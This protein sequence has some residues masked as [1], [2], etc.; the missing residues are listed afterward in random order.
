MPEARGLRQ[1]RNSPAVLA[2]W[3]AL[4]MGCMTAGS[5]PRER[6]TG[7]SACSAGAPQRT[8]TDPRTM[9]AALPWNRERIAFSG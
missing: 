1:R 9:A 5:P 4:H 6:G 7:W 3:Q 2:W 8:Q